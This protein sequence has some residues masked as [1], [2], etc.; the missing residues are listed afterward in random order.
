MDEQTRRIEGEQAGNGMPVPP[1]TQMG[2]GVPP[3]PQ[4]IPPQVQ[5]GYG[6]PPTPQQ[7]PP[8]AQMGYG[9]PPTPQQISPQTQM[10]YGVPPASQ[11]IPPQAQMPYQI[12]Q[13]YGYTRNDTVSSGMAIASMVLGIMS[14]IVCS[15]FLL[16]MGCAVAGLTLGCVYRAKGGTNGMSIAG[17]ACSSVG[18]ALG[19][20]VITGTFME[21]FY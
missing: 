17:I 21:F 12:P 4:Q 6:V 5:M 18:L 2:Y 19:F 8:Q 15:W 13:P 1:Q 7:I 3:T 9:V 11:Q 14:I 10:G 20:L 16:G